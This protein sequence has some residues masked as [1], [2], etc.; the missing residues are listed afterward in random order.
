MVANRTIT[1]KIDAITGILAGQRSPVPP[2]PKSVKIELTARCNFR[3]SYCARGMRLRDQKD[4]DSALFERLLPTFR[5]AGVEEIGLFYLGESFLLPWLPEA[6]AYARAVGFP[7]VFLTTNGSL[8]RPDAVEA[9]MKAGLNS[10]KFSLNYADETQFAEIAGVK[11]K[12]FADVLEN[13]RL[14]KQIRD[15]GGYDCGVFASYIQYDGDQGRRMQSVVDMV[16]PWVD[17]IYALPLYSQ[18]DLVGK[19]E[20]EKG[21]SVRAGNPG[22]LGNMREPI[23]CWALFTEARV[24]HDGHLSACCFDHD[25]RFHMGDLKRMDFMT[26]WHSPSFQELRKAHLADDVRG[27]VCENCVAYG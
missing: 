14:A 19:S 26:A 10:L 11:S 16:R 1:D 8:A 4:M 24:T 25:G 9:C 5:A 12:I 23:P 2:C 22:R 15:R 21:W 17:E 20:T 13:L 27:T 3:C 6:I 18:A 7:Y